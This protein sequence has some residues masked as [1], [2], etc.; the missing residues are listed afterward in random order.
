[1]AL[2]KKFLTF[3]LLDGGTFGICTVRAG[4]A[5]IPGKESE[6]AHGLLTTLSPPVTR[7]EEL[8]IAFGVGKMVLLIAITAPAKVLAL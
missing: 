7:F 8:A 1:M 3:V 6:G 5:E 2:I 4:S